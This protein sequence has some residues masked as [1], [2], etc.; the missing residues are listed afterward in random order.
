MHDKS[1]ILYL[2]KQNISFGLDVIVGRDEQTSENGELII[3]E[4]LLMLVPTFLMRSLE[5]AER[6]FDC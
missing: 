1:K 4:L 2:C 5:V 3:S 6:S